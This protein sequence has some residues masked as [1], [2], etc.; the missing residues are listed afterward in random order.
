MRSLAALLALVMALTLAPTALAALSRCPK[1]ERMTLESSVLH[2]ATCHDTGIIEYTCTNQYCDYTTLQKTDVNPN[3]HDVIY[4]DNG[5]GTH[6]GACR[7]HATYTIKSE[8][9]RYAN[10]ACELCAAPN[11]T[12]V[13]MVGLDSDKVVPVAVGDAG[14]KLSASGIRLVLGS[15]NITE[16]YTLQYHWYDNNQNGREVGTS[17]E[18]L[19][20]A[21]VYGKEGTYYYNLV[22]FASPKSTLSRPPVSKTCRFTVQ[23]EDLITVS[24]A[25]TTQDGELYFSELDGWSSDSIVNQIYDGVQGLC[26]RDAKP[27]SVTFDSVTPTSIGKLSA[28]SVNTQYT[29]GDTKRDLGDVSF[30]HEG[31]PGEFTVGFTAYDTEG[32]S[33]KGVL[34]IT[35][36]QY[37]GDMDVLYIASRSEPLTLG[38]QEFEDFWSV[39][40]PNGVLEYVMFDQLPKSVEGVLYSDYVSAAFPG[41]YVRTNDELFVDPP[42]N[43]YALDAVTFVPGVGVRQS[44]YITLKFTAHGTRTGTREVNRSGLVYIFFNGGDKGADITVPATAAGAALKP[45]DFQKAYQSVMGAA[46]ANFY[47]QLIDIPKGGS[48]Y[49]GRTAGKNGV[50][51][52]ADTIEGRLFSYSDARGETIG[53]L[54]YVPGT[55]ASET[56]RY[57]ASSTQGKP[58][59]AGNIHFTSSG[60]PTVSNLYVDYRCNGTGVSFKSSDFENLAG[61]GVAKL[62]SVTFTPPQAAMG[63]LYYGRT[64][65]AA[66]QPITTDN[67]WFN[68]SSGAGTISVNDISFVPAATYT[69]GLVTIPFTA[70][71]TAGIRS[72][73]TVRIT[74][75]PSPTNQ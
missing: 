6:S 43:Q 27:Y 38:A 28:T 20:P 67:I 70:I 68:L 50:L 71:N 56:I 55:A 64:A 45:A 31:V 34:T 1:C 29:F 15:A 37:A 41:S 10:G 5:D 62:S 26:G 52:T 21:S 60:I 39:V 30:T 2:E 4:T 72:T 69:S 8:A 11:Y 9:H 46:A 75:T 65:V 35:V 25:V 66:G 48:L 24:A 36:Q 40:C 19:L 3:R 18:F 17:E 14:A 51:L 47:I 54:T 63:S 57:V 22:V 59:F 42:R 7:Y 16:D 53:G 12:A 13:E 23:V 73:G 58:L 33:Y 32:E 44:D 49:S 61:A 74:V